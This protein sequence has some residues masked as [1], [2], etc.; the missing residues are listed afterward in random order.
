MKIYYRFS[1]NNMPNHLGE[2]R[3]SPNRPAWFNKWHCL[4]NFVNVFKNHDI[5]IVADKLDPETVQK[6]SKFYP[7]TDIHLTDFGYNAGSFLY[8]LELARK[9]PADTKVYFVED[10]YLHHEG[11]DIIL[12]QGLDICPYV[13]LYDHPDKYWNENADKLSKI[14]MSED[15]HWR[16]TGST[17]MTFGTTVSYLQEDRESF[18]RWCGGTDNWTH[19]FQLFTE[20]SNTRGLITPLPGYATH[21]DTWVIAKM[22][23][24]KDVVDRTST[25]QE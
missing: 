12:E 11:S 25:Y 22:V 9:L 6:L 18:Y 4:S 2:K 13:S 17:T 8:S 3:N 10:D 20:L 19:D 5:T 1:F 24:W 21:M 15:C 14:L 7:D 23:D 16:T